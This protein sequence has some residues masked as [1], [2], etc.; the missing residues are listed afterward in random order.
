MFFNRDNHKWIQ[1]YPYL[2][3]QSCPGIG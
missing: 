3:H 1:G 2:P